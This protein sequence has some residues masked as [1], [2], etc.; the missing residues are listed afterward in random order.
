L[1]LNNSTSITYSEQL[2]VP[3]VPMDTA[4]WHLSWGLVEN[5]NI[6][7]VYIYRFFA[8][9]IGERFFNALDSLINVYNVDGLIL[10]LRVNSGGYFQMTNAGLDLLFDDEVP[11]L[12]LAIRNDP[13]DHFSMSTYST[14]NLNVD[15]NTY[16]NKPIAILSG[17]L[18]ISA[19][20]FLIKRMKS[21]PY[22]KVFGKTSSSA[23][24][25]SM[26]TN[27]GQ[28]NI[29]YAYLNGFSYEDPNQYLTHLEME[30]DYEV[31][32]TP[33][34]AK[35]GDDTV[36][37]TALDWIES[38]INAV[39][40]SKTYVLDFNLFQN[41]PNPFNPGTKIKFT[42]P[43][44]ERR[45]TK[46]VTLKVYDMLGNEIATLINEEKPAGNYEVGFDADVYNLSSGVYFY[47]LKAGDQIKM[48]KM[49]LLK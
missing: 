7:Y 29:N 32:F 8:S 33:N 13:F 18:C 34:D 11:R 14:Y 10:D 27:I 47:Q 3:G 19:G 21:H 40:E 42:I 41:Y 37:K 35:N 48:K 45:K 5:T 1:L 30:V 24:A 23:F 6:G 36:V 46:D 38:T 43:Q 26:M 39:N 22:I 44:D 17:P 15:T 31:S 16:F 28:I 25:S 49:L 4:H 20:E 9:N 12:G 2:P